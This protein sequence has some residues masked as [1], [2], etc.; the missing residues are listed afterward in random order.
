MEEYQNIGEQE[1]QRK[2]HDGRILEKRKS[3]AEKN[4][5]EKYWRTGRVVQKRT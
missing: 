3:S 4:L 2:D 5:M 1:E